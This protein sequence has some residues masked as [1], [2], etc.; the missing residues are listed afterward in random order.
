MPFTGQYQPFNIAIEPAQGGYRVQVLDSPDGQTEGFFVLPFTHSPAG[1]V[2]GQSS[3]EDIGGQLFNALFEGPVGEQLRASQA[4]TSTAAGLRINLR[5]NNAPELASLPWELLYD[6]THHR[7]LALS[8]RTPINR[9]LALP[10]AE[11]KL[12]VQPPLRILALLC[13]P[14]DYEPQLQV[15]VEYARLQAALQAPIHATD[16]VLDKLDN[17][18]WP[19]LQ[20]YLRQHPVHILH[21]VGHGYYDARDNSGGLIFEDD[22]GLG[23]KI[24]ARRLAPLLH[25]HSSLRLAVLNACA[26]AVASSVD[27]FTGVAQTLAQQGLPA[28]VAMQQAISDQAAVLFAETLY[29]AIADH[30]PLDA[31]LSQARIALNGSSSRE[32]ATPVLFLRSA[33]AAIFSPQKPQLDKSPAMKWHPVGARWLGIG[34]AGLV[35]LVGVGQLYLHSNPLLQSVVGAILALLAALV[36]L[37]GIRNDPTL[38][39]RLSQYVAKV[40]TAR[41]GM[42]GLLALGLVL[43]TVWGF[44]ELGSAN[45]HPI[46]GCKPDGEEWFAVAEWKSTGDLTPQEQS[47]AAN[48][49][50]VIYQKLNLVDGLSGIDL[51]SPQLGGEA[52]AG[53]DIWLIGEYQRFAVSQLS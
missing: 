25:S 15:D 22:A 17:A 44:N 36:G 12:V 49:R 40:P 37:L 18:T 9:Y 4:R 28:V 7:F 6:T 47:L 53:L 33:D 8:Q 34:L 24:S 35:L 45:C 2:S 41:W 11:E 16:V 39:P 42:G 46:L 29:A 23:Q 5:L 10:L 43:W 14:T 20:S 51:D 32:W 30:Y 1:W 38:F 31:A 19:A 48:M 50:R 21:F 52:V 26:G 13:A 27:P 3:L